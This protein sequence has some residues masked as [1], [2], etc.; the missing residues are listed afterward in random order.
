MPSRQSPFVFGLLVLLGSTALFAVGTSLAVL[1]IARVLQGASTAVVFTVGFALLF[2]KVGKEQ[3]GEAM[4]WTSMSLSLGLFSGPIVGGIV[5]QNLGYF[6]VFL[7]AFLLLALEIILRFLIIEDDRFAKERSLLDRDEPSAGYGA[8]DGASDSDALR[9]TP[10]PGQSKGPANKT[11]TAKPRR[12]TLIALLTSPRLLVAMGGLFVIN[13]FTTSMEG[14]LPVYV[15][16]LFHVNSTQVA[17]IFL[18]MTI[19]ML[20]SPVTGM[21]VDRVGAKWP[22][23]AGFG[24]GIPTLI[25]LRFASE[26]TETHLFILCAVLFLFGCAVSLA[27][28]SIMTEVTF[29]VEEI[30]KE[31]PNIFGDGGAVSQAYGLTNAAFAGGALCGPLY[32]GFLRE[33]FGW[34]TMTLVMGMISATM[35]LLC[36]PFS[37]GRLY[38]RLPAQAE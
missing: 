37:G 24:L 31:D 21:L 26:N 16:E 29:A 7:P 23:V 11:Q 17:L 34:P 8:T 1:L 32:A 30:E 38:V 27:L 12:S 36:I 22:A 9:G 14:V 25:C 15:K 2:D 5:Y 3:I 6:A 4:G 10:P 19:P 20:M 18:N 13:S 28:P 33:S 35:M